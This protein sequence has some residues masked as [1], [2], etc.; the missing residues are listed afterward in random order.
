MTNITKNIK[1]K[2]LFLLSQVT[3]LNPSGK[4]M[5]ERNNKGQCKELW[6]IGNGISYCRKCHVMNDENI[7]KSLARARNVC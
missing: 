7:G 6:D 5:I 3:Y 4:T 1:E 2:R